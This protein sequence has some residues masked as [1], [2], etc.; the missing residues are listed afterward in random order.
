MPDESTPPQ[1]GVPTPLNLC[2]IE[3]LMNEVN[4]RCTSLIIMAQ[5]PYGELDSQGKPLVGSVCTFKENVPFAAMGMAVS[6]QHRIQAHY[7]QKKYFG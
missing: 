4:R 6:I 3:D 5:F 7:E 2:S 1:E